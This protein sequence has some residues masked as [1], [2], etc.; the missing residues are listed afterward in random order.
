MTLVNA[1]AL[2]SAEENLVL[3]VVLVLESNLQYNCLRDVRS[4][5]LAQER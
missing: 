2:L 4:F 5:L 1:E 3:V